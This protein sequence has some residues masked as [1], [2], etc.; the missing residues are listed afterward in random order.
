MGLGGAGGPCVGDT[1][2]ES[3]CPGATSASARLG[4]G[5]K[6]PVW[7]WVLP[8]AGHQPCAP[9]PFPTLCLGRMGEPVLSSFPSSATG[10]FPRV[11]QSPLGR[12]CPRGHHA[13]SPLFPPPGCSEQARP[14][15]RGTQH[16]LAML[17]PAQ[18]SPRGAQLVAVGERDPAPQPGAQAVPQ[19]CS[20]VQ[21]GENSSL[22][23]E[24]N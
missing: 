22:S 10:L 19:P 9:L 23:A 16:S 1:A 12:P 17:L 20:Q 6:V 15:T 5:R 8:R 11:S 18:M 14:H 3:R 4:A 21:W 13:A 7:P 2:R 24:T